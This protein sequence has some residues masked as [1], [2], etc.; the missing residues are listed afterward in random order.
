[1]ARER[2]EAVELMSQIYIRM[3]VDLLKAEDV[4]DTVIAEGEVY[5][6]TSDKL[7]G[8]F[9]FA[10]ADQSNTP[11]ASI[12]KRQELVELLPILQGL[13]VDPTKIKEE[14]IRQFDLPKQ[15]AEAVPVAEPVAPPAA[16]VGAAM[17]EVADPSQLP[18]E[19]LAA[20]LAQSIPEMPTSTPETF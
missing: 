3:L 6:V 1:M 10:A 19:A 13:G 15:F 20:Q 17:P 11:I 7:E 9:R 16:A 8:K 2:D 4:E 12:I 14:L 5:R 18:S